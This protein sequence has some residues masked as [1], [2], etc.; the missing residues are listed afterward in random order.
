MADAQAD[1]RMPVLDFLTH[2]QQDAERPIGGGVVIGFA[3]V[4][5]LIDEKGNRGI[6]K[7]TS[8]ASGHPLP[9]YLVEGLSTAMTEEDEFDDK[10]EEE[11]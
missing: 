8:D 5:E 2:G 11:D 6:A 7:V 3:M 4:I 9:W 1:M 10:L